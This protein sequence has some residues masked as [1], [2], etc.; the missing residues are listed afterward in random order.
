[1]KKYMLV[2]LVLLS[3]LS[4]TGCGGSA[5][6]NNI[7]SA[8]TSLAQIRVNLT[9]QEGTQIT[10]AEIKLYTPVAAMR[11]GLSR[12]NSAFSFRASVSSDFEQG[13]YSPIGKD[14]D[15]NYLFTIPQG[16]YV[17]IAEKDDVK[18]VI[19][20]IRASRG[21]FVLT[22]ALTP[23]G[24]I[25]GKVVDEMGN[26]LS[27]AILYL[28][29][30]S[31][32]AFSNSEGKFEITGVPTG[33]NY[34]LLAVYTRENKNLT[35][36]KKQVN[37]NSSLLT[38]AL[39]ENLVLQAEASGPTSIKG[40][41]STASATTLEKRIIMA[42]KGNACYMTI[43]NGQGEFV[44][45]LKEGGNYVVTPMD[46]AF[47]V[48][49]VVNVTFGEVKTLEDFKLS[50]L[51]R[52]YSVSGKIKINSDYKGLAEN[53]MP[54]AGRFLIR[55]VGKAPN[56]YSAST[57][58]DY[59]QSVTSDTNGGWNYI[60]ENVP[61]GEYY[62][63][64]DPNGNGFLGCEGSVSV[65][66]TV[67][68][69]IIS[70]DYIKPSFDINIDGGSLKFEESD[71]F[72]ANSDD[73]L[74]NVDIVC[75]SNKSATAMKLL[76]TDIN[77]DTT[78]SSSPHLKF[79]YNSSLPIGDYEVSMSK[80]WSYP[81][82]GLAGVVVTKSPKII[83]YSAT[84]TVIGQLYIKN[85]ALSL[86]SLAMGDECLKIKYNGNNTFS[87]IIKDYDNNKRLEHF[88][89]SSTIINTFISEAYE[90]LD[91]FEDK[92][93][94][95][96][97]SVWVHG[98]SFATPIEVL[99][100]KEADFASMY[101]KYISLS[102]LDNNKSYVSLYMLND[103]TAVTEIKKYETHGNT[104]TWNQGLKSGNL[105]SWG[106]EVYMALLTNSYLGNGKIEIFKLNSDNTPVSVVDFVFADG[107]KLNEITDFKCLSSDVFYIE[108]ND[109]DK[110]CFILTPTENR[111]E[112]SNFLAR[113]GCLTDKYGYLY[114]YDKSTEKIVKVD[115]L[116]GETLEYSS[117]MTINSFNDFL[118]IIGDTLY[119]W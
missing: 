21:N 91:C 19:Q 74:A 6:N 97:A 66:G 86:S 37:V 107:T 48:S 47:P 64:V 52:G 78:T 111:N 49:Q 89:L 26:A 90:L 84:D 119:A 77:F 43:S 56:N 11:A 27:G 57:S 44:F 30:T 85:V 82:I 118:S 92:I 62:I 76:K 80:R 87:A 102:Y 116:D 70:V 8:D 94:Y 1:M 5:S 17:L 55:L 83:N 108:T 22:A 54:K 93:V 95:N 53:E 2:L 72:M 98:S 31:L 16:E 101:D 7:N 105:A 104:T 58:A 36:L 3:M 42:T 88:S 4:L 15:G 106:G 24:T 81:D 59:D 29:N 67:T 9:S 40:K 38:F 63:L 75:Y 113:K 51:M 32:V 69:K 71:F 35:S 61:A 33:V 110:Y 41:F 12:A 68:G 20:G 99:N 60:F 112:S 109:A 65:S 23:K 14:L 114:R 10:E 18:T 117:N 100:G 46:A 79:T 45:S 13:I 96:N 73:F 103:T 25:T 28:E 34:D 50:T 39:A 115:S